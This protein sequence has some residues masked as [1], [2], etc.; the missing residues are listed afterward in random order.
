M[1]RVKGRAAVYHQLL[2]QHAYPYLESGRIG[3]NSHLM[4]DLRPGP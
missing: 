4:I 3:V 1:H 2:R